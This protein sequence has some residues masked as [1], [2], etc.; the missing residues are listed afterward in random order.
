[1]LTSV[2]FD[3]IDSKS[4]K[5]TYNPSSGFVAATGWANCQTGENTLIPQSWHAYFNF[6][7]SSLPDNAQVTKVEF[8]IRS[9]KPPYIDPLAY[10]VGFSIGTFIGAALDGNAEEWGGGAYMVTILSR[11]P[12][13]TWLDLAVAGN[14]PRGFVNRA[15]DTDIQA[16]DYSIGDTEHWT[17]ITSFNT[18]KAKCQLRVTYSLPS[19]TATGRGTVAATAG[20]VLPAAG[21]ATGTGSVQATA[22][23]ISA[24][25][26]E[27]TGR[28]VIAASANV[29][30]PAAA[31]ATGIGSALVTAAVVITGAAAAT[32]YGTAELTAAILASG[33]AI[34][35]G[36]GSATCALVG[37]YFEP[38]ARHMGTRAVR[39]AHVEARSVAWVHTGTRKARRLI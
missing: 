39:T 16:F 24:G 5:I 31:L 9:P 2:V 20:V 1:M 26:A 27:A 4:G 38:P 23:V 37:T 18:S 12:D 10:R 14:D 8:L 35:T 32:G 3:F 36:R 25:S 11:A 22:I 13:N 21:I 28:G 34:A 17:W 30:L 29:I 15:G 7:T 6:N 33:V 19:A